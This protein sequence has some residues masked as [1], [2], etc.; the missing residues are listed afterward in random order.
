MNSRDLCMIEHL[1][2]MLEAGISSFKIEGAQ[3]RVLSAVNTNATGMLWT[4]PKRHASAA[5]LAQ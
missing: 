2:A 5:G 1:L 4:P 3:V